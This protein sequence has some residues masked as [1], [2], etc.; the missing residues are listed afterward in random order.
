MTLDGSTVVGSTVLAPGSQSFVAA[1]ASGTAWVDGIFTSGLPLLPLTPLAS[2]GNSF[3]VRVNSA[4]LIDQTARFGGLAAFSPLNASAPVT[5][6][7]IAIDASGNPLLAGSFQPSASQ[8]LLATQT[9]DLPLSNAPTTAFPTAVHGAVL[10]ASACSGSL[11]PGAA[12]YLAKLTIPS[13]ISAAKASL[14]LSVDDSPNLTLRNLGSAQATGI[15]IAVS[16]F[17]SA[18]N[19]ATTL[20]EGAECSIALSGIGSGSITVTANNSTSQTQILPTLAT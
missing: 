16:S 17:T 3:A 4:N 9:F 1:G 2:F 13:S 15:S 19:C 8:S 11:C 10:P 6:T 14:A 18:T 7:S 5:L 12:S 20:A